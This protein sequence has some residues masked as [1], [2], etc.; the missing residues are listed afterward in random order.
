M[1]ISSLREWAGNFSTN[2]NYLWV[3]G[4][5]LLSAVVYWSIR[6]RQKRSLL[7]KS[8]DES[9]KIRITH[10]G[11]Q[12]LLHM[13]CSSFPGLVQAKS[14]IVVDEEDRL[15]PHIKFS[16][17]NEVN[18]KDIQHELKARIHEI[19]EKH[20]GKDQIGEIDFTVTGFHAKTESEPK[21][22]LGM[23]DTVPPVTSIKPVGNNPVDKTLGN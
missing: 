14:R 8:P 16:I 19:L 13:A 23:E 7:V 11:L 18:L 6:Q 3:S 2:L 5:I 15:S 12:D 1:P 20:L 10:A 9:F 22:I 21:D 17:S 4:L